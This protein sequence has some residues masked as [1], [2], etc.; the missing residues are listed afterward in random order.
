MADAYG[1]HVS[2]PGKVGAGSTFT[3]SFHGLTPD[4]Q[5]VLIF[6]ATTIGGDVVWDVAILGQWVLARA[7]LFVAYKHAEEALAN[8]GITATTGKMETR[9]RMKRIRDGV[10]GGGGA[11]SGGAPGTGQPGEELV[12]EDDDDALRRASTVERALRCVRTAAGVILAPVALAVL[13]HFLS[14]VAMNYVGGGN[15]EPGSMFPD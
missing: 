7:P 14:G 11:T 6:A 9:L 2:A 8:V 15:G 13:A 12:L 3:G 5:T 1:Y 4:E 10:D